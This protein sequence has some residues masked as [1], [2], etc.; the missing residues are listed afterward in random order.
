ML[1][2]GFETAASAGERPETYVLDR[3]NTDIGTV[4]IIHNL[5]VGYI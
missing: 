5:R 3:A 4:K 2:V 1:P